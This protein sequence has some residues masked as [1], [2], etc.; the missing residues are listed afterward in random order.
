MFRAAVS[1][2]GVTVRAPRA[3]AGRLYP[4]LPSYSFSNHL[5]HY[6]FFFFPQVSFLIMASWRG[7]VHACGVCMTCVWYA[8]DMRM[9]LLWSGLAHPSRTRARSGGQKK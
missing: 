7:C 2:T 5:V 9:L 8:C 6:L 1:G 3:G 4:T